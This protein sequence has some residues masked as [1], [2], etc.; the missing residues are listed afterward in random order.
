MRSPVT[1]FTPVYFEK[2]NTSLS[3]SA[4]YQTLK[5][6]VPVACCHAPTWYENIHVLFFP[7]RDKACL[8]EPFIKVF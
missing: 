4:D 6:L 7:H 8:P 2:P 5:W 3:F 1:I